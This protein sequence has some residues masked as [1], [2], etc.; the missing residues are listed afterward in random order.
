[1]ELRWGVSGE[2]G[3]RTPHHHFPNTIV[4]HIWRRRFPKRTWDGG[5]C[6]LSGGFNVDAILTDWF[7]Q[8]GGVPSYTYS[9]VGS[10]CFS[11]FSANE[12]DSHTMVSSHR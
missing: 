9:L 7:R 4:T 5:M 6:P 3:R 10:R 1:M 8:Q 2:E 12:K 11:L